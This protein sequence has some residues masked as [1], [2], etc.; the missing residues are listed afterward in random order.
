MLQGTEKIVGRPQYIEQLKKWQSQTDLI[1]IVTGVRRCGK[2]KLFFPFREHHFGAVNL[3]GE[4]VTGDF[5]D[6]FDKQQENSGHKNQDK[7]KDFVMFHEG[8]EIL[9]DIGVQ[10]CNIHV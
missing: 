4:N 9:P 6:F 1:K 8:K 7:R 5:H 10:I 2:S 3:A